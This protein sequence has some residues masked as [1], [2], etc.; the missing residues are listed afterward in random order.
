MNSQSNNTAIRRS[1]SVR[2][3]LRPIQ[4]LLDDPTVFEVT[5]N[6][7][8]EVWTTSFQDRKLYKIETLSMKYLQDLAKAILV[9]NGKRNFAAS[10]SV[11]LPSGERGHI[12]M[13]PG[14]HDGFIGFSF[15][16]N[17]KTVKTLDELH[18]EG[19]FDRFTDV[20]FNLPTHDEAVEKTQLKDFT[21]L[22][23]FEV[24]LLRLKRE[25]LIDEFLRQC[26]LT[27][28]NICIVGKTGS[29]KTTFIRALINEIPLHE[30]IVSIE[31]VFELLIKHPNHLALKY[32]DG[33]GHA[34]AKECLAATMRL[35]PDRIFLA[36][37]RGD[38]A[39][40][41]LST[42]SNSGHPGSITT[43][44][45][46]SAIL[47]FSRIAM[48]IKQS[49][50]GKMLDIE[51]IQKVLYTSIDV[52]LFFHDRELVELFYDPIFKKQYLM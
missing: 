17:M 15:R 13:P 8:C 2:Q 5:I 32:G 11:V 46:D 12:M 24:E 23:H 6:K 25:K 31:D 38:E 10:A 3:F 36:E 33:E 49:P 14:V 35:L 52:V 42:V 7:P 28:R 18:Q 39:W 21:R 50:I 27:K 37:L 26:V 40:D 45:A 48:L 51:L 30:R 44:H 1:E 19:R 34:T 22:D 9:Y 47:A 20:S 41:Y 4:H 16:K 29:G 43:V